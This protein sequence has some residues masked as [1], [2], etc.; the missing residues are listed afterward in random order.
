MKSFLI[1]VAGIAVGVVAATALM[2]ALKQ[3]ETGKKVLGAA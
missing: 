1:T 3:T 2:V